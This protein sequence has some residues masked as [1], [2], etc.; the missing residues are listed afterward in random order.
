MN[1]LLVIRQAMQEKR[2]TVGFVAYRTGI[3]ADVLEQCLSGKRPFKMAEFL[4]VCKVLE[5]TPNSFGLQMGSQ[6][7][8]SNSGISD[9]MKYVWYY[10]EETETTPMKKKNTLWVCIKRDRMLYLMLI[11]MFLI[12]MLFGY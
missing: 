5:L 1:Y 2:Y 6:E 10:I 7:W 4:K 9:G 11:P 3:P 8:N 12:F